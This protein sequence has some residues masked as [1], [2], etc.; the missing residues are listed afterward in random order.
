MHPVTLSR[1]AALPAQPHL[2][3]R[4]SLCLGNNAEFNQSQANAMLS[5]DRSSIVHLATHGEF[6]SD[7]EKT[8]ILTWDS[9]F[10]LD[11]LKYILQHRNLQSGQVID[12]LVLSAGEIANSR[13]NLDRLKY[14]LQHRNLQSGQVI[15]LLVLSAGEIASGDHRATLSLAGVAIEA[16]TNITIASLWKVNDQATQLLMANFYQNLAAK[17]L[18]KA[19]SLK[20]AQQSLLDNPQYYWPAFELLGNWQ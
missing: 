20:L 8:F 17:K 3:F 6:S 4:K 10:N 18:G 5:S 14:I 15:D 1:N 2:T 9:R 13:L 19:E 12:L 11:R 7:P 16:R